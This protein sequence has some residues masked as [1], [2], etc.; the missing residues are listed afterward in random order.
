MNV[1]LPEGYYQVRLNGSLVFDELGWWHYQS[2]LRKFGG[3]ESEED[4]IIAFAVSV[5]LR[6]RHDAFWESRA[7]DSIR[8][9]ANR[10]RHSRSGG[11]GCAAI[12]RSG[13]GD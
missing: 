9:E 2:D 4:R 1:I 8:N 12:S 10:L 11:G 5:L 6:A 3:I 7:S 13:G